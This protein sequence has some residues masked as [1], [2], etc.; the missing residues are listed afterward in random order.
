[1]EDILGENRRR[2]GGKYLGVR[3]V[4]RQLVGLEKCF[5]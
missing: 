5:L 4:I 3:R 2:L 1:M